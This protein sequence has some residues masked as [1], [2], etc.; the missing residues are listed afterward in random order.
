M[1]ADG[2]RPSTN[3]IASIVNSDKEII[4]LSQLQ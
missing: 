4:N 3:E 1:S 2:S